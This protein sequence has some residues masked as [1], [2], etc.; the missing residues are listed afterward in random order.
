MARNTV[1]QDLNITGHKIGTDGV[2]KLA[3]LLRVN[4]SLLSFTWD[5]NALTMSGAFTLFSVN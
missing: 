1:I 2:I 3:H 4:R 5:D